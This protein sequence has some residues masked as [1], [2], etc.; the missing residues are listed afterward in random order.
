MT[1][2][3]VTWQHILKEIFNGT[4]IINNIE[5]NQTSECI[6]KCGIICEVGKCLFDL[7]NK[8]ISFY[9]SFNHYNTT[10]CKETWHA[11]NMVNIIIL[12]LTQGFC[13][14]KRDALERK[15]KHTVGKFTLLNLSGQ[16]LRYKLIS[17]LKKR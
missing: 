6:S 1:N 10:S 7:H 2:L 8:E 14:I 3:H 5:S 13:L 17:S 9:H 12:M 15:T 16:D 11:G 4:L